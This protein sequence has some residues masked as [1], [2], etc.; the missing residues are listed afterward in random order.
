MES[1]AEIMA[2]LARMDERQT[3]LETRLDKMETKQERLYYWVLGLMTAAVVSLAA[4]A[5]RVLLFPPA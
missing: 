2:M 3:N 4:I 5:V 1:Q